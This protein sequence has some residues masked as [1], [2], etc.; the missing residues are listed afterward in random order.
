M[1]ELKK[2]ISIVE[3]K[4]IQFNILRQV[5]NFCEKNNLRYFLAYGTL[6]G[7]IRHKGFIPWD[8]DTDIWMPRK[9]YNLFLDKFNSNESY[10][11]INPKE[12]IAKHSYAKVIDTQTIKIE[13]NIKYN[14]FLG[15]DIDV[16][17][18]DGVPENEEDSILF[19]EK[20]QKIYRKHTV[21]ILYPK[22]RNILRNIKIIIKKLFSVDRKKLLLQAEEMHKE[23]P[24]EGC[25]YVACY[26][27]SF[28]SIKNR[29]LKSD[30]EDYI[31][32]EFEGEM[33]RAP[34]G[35]DRI[36]KNIYGNYM[37][38]PPEE[39]RITHHTNKIFWR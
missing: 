7:A 12:D 9:D 26:E 2:P 27:S 23:Y 20:L 13:P 16:F 24:Y 10:R 31:M 19:Y 30:F 37:Q 38:L 28:N 18:L 14:Q 36:L 1:K 15:I 11:V 3:S 8:D 32:V 25:K 34:I 5:A 6:I 35:Y 29:S 39:K 4:K 21:C 33:F 22:S 17:P